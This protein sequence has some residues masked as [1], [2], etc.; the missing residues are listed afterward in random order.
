MPRLKKTSR[1]R[2]ADAAGNSAAASP[3]RRRAAAKKSHAAS[4]YHHGD[5]HRALLAATEALVETAGVEGFTLREVARRA[6][7]SHGAP[8]HHFGDVR[9]LLSEFTAESFAQLAAAMRQRR[10]R[11]GTASFDQLVATGVGYVDY[12]LA[13]RARFQLMFR[14]ERLDR[15]RAS[16]AAAGAEAYG[17]LAECIAGVSREAGASPALDDEKVALAWSIVHGFAT[18]MIDNTKFAQR[19]GGRSAAR[20]IE[21]LARLI[22]ASR[23]A[24]ERRSQ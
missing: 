18:L 8:A 6:G 15:S 19:V 20:A 17:Q 10:E 23:P 7:V 2:A 9:G 1:G 14:S 16:L 21:V 5:L 11:A 13:H 3:P 24:F 4:A 12:A 22:E